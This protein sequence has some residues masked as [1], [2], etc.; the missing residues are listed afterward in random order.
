R[1]VLQ[2]MR[3]LSGQY[4]LGRTIDEAQKRG[5]KINCKDTRFSFDMLGEGARSEKQ[6]RQYRA[7]YLNAIEK[8]G[9][10]NSTAQVIDANGIS[11]KLSALHPR[12][13]YVQRERVMAEL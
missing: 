6:A 9:K 1:A 11:I 12:Y 7:A 8:T 10:A 2:A 5:P 4:I 3:V 13:E